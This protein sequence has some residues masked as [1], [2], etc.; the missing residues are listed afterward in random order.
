MRNAK[1]CLKCDHDTIWKV[2]PVSF[3]N[4]EYAGSIIPLPV[5]CR[6]VDNPDGGLLS[7]A[8]RR[9]TV[10]RFIAYVCAECG[11]TE[12]YAQDIDD[13]GELQRGER[14]SKVRK[15]TKQE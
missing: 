2:D 8:T 1:Q 6:I 5:A 15:L 14:G 4:E 9:K 3:F 11:Y 12:W 13:I 10:G 7:S